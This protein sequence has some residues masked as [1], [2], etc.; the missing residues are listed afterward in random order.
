MEEE[1]RVVH[2]DKV[3]RT[4]MEVEGIERGAGLV[5]LPVFFPG[6]LGPDEETWWAEKRS[7]AAWRGG[8]AEK[9]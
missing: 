1:S 4:L 9:V 7:E 3:M 8:N 6:K 2:N 5:L